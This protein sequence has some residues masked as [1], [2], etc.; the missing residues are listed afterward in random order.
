MAFASF[1]FACKKE[2]GGDTPQPPNTTKDTLLI[3]KAN[4]TEVDTLQD[5]YNSI[6]GHNYYIYGKRRTDG[7]IVQITSMAIK[8]T[9][10][11]DSILNVIYDDSLRVSNYY[12][13]VNG[14]KDKALISMSYDQ[15]ITNVSQYW[16]NWATGERLIRYKAQFKKTNTNT[17][18]AVNVTYYRIQ[19]TQILY[20]DTSAILEANIANTYGFAAIS[21]TI[22]TVNNSSKNFATAIKYFAPDAT[23]NI[24]PIS[25]LTSQTTQLPAGAPANPSSQWNYLGSLTQILIK[26]HWLGVQTVERHYVNGVVVSTDYQ[27]I[28]DATIDFSDNSYTVIETGAY[29]SACTGTYSLNQLGYTNKIKMTGCDLE[30]EH[31]VQKITYNELVILGE[32]DGTS[33]NYYQ[34]TL[35]LRK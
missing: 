16:L 24:F 3:V 2:K 20:N 7:S 12:F 23:K 4:F 34:T 1:L 19:G 30:G 26:G 28:T 21:E 5:V 10:Q 27:D 25:A 33:A 6:K 9:T 8:K 29:P 17:L 18:S 15:D 31:E 22:N 14:K 32:K 13:I 11:A 35:F